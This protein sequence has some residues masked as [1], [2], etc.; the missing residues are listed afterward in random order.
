MAPSDTTSG[1]ERRPESESGSESE[2]QRASAPT[3]GPSEP[4]ILHRTRVI[5]VAGSALL[6]GAA[7]AIGYGLAR[8]IWGYFLLSGVLAVVGA[9]ALW[10]SLRPWRFEI[11]GGGVY[12]RRAGIDRLIRWSEV[13][14]IVLVRI[15]APG[16]G[17]SPQFL[18]TPKSDTFD[19]ARG[20]ISPWN[21][22]PSALLLDT[23]SVREPT[24]V[25]AAAMAARA[26]GKFHDLRG[27]PG[28]GK[29][30]PGDHGSAST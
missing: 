21:D 5:A 10:E 28:A 20:K 3:P 22:R 27:I 19:L 4:T 14:V 24:H 25:I 2:S 1:P 23:A 12:V 17:A 13:D 8:D 11:G 9:S 29:S 6:A 18:L 26:D 7:A 15:T 16:G 30:R